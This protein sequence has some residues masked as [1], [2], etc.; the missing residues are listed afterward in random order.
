[1]E[2]LHKLIV[3]GYYSSYLVFKTEEDAQR[4]VKSTLIRVMYVAVLV[5]L[6]YFLWDFLQSRYAMVWVLL[7]FLMYGQ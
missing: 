7:V 3:P 2:L 1:M 4:T 6:L 5:I